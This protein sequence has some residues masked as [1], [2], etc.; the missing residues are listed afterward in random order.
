MTCEVVHKQE[1]LQMAMHG[2]AMHPQLAVQSLA[3]L[4]RYGRAELD[5][6]WWAVDSNAALSG[7]PKPAPGNGGRVAWHARPPTCR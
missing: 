7:G 4:G 3:L 6:M 1:I 5:R 2:S